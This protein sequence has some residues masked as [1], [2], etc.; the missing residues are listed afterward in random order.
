MDLEISFPLK[1]SNIILAS[2][3]KTREK[4]LKDA[5]IS[6]RLFPVDCPE[7]ALKAEFLKKN[8]S[9]KDISGQLALAKAQIAQKKLQK[10]TDFSQNQSLIIGADQILECEGELYNKPKTLEE[11]EKQLWG[12]RGKTQFLHTSF[13]LL[14]ERQPVVIYT[15]SPKLKMRH[16]SEAFLKAFID[17]EGEELLFCVGACRIEGPGIQLF[18][19]I[20]GAQETILGL[21]LFP[22]LSALR[23]RKLLPV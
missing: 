22:L 2:G 15:E 5:G 4:I 6:P 23:E 8:D 11:A 14:Q 13:C 17:F 10:E 21:P 19:K 20:E 1:R 16:F 18:E 3:S 7:E 12:M 9:L